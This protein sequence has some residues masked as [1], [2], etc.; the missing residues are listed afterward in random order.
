MGVE[1][2]FLH[3]QIGRCLEIFWSKK[4]TFSTNFSVK[5]RLKIIQFLCLQKY[6]AHLGNKSTSNLS[7]QIYKKELALDKE[8]VDVATLVQGVIVHMALIT[9]YLYCWGI[10]RKWLQNSRI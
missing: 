1:I 5:R 4:A 9:I 2:G 7:D 10:D 3:Y 6:S 8:L